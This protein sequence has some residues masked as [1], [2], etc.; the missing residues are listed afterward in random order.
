VGV[1]PLP[2]LVVMRKVLT[3]SGSN[4]A[5]EKREGMKARSMMGYTEKHP[6]GTTPIALPLTEAL[7]PA[8]A[9]APTLNPALKARKAILTRFFLRSTDSTGDDHESKVS[10]RTRPYLI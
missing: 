8:P 10:L 3:S 5:G 2:C 1:V 6:A 4:F 9:P 7:A